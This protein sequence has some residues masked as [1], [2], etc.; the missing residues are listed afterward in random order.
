MRLRMR[1]TRGLPL[2]EQTEQKDEDEHSAI[3]GGAN[4][5]QKPPVRSSMI[6]RTAS[7]GQ[8]R[9]QEVPFIIS[10]IRA[11]A[12]NDAA[13]KDYPAIFPEEVDFAVIPMVAFDDSLMRLG[14]GGGNYDS[15]LS[16]MRRM[17]Q[18]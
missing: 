13:V 12:T 8:Y 6:M 11:Y 18:S 9:T 14:Y 15:F 1:R 2:H 5:A 10:P 16:A 4:R 17:P 3:N 7:Y